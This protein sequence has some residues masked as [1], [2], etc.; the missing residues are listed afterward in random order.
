[1]AVQNKDV[2]NS[3]PIINSHKN[4]FW[5][6][7]FELSKNLFYSLKMRVFFFLLIKILV[8]LCSVCGFVSISFFLSK[9]LNFHILNSS[10]DINHP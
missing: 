10:T 9:V 6:T 3:K 5:N 7:G 8:F 2:I 4:I 1:M